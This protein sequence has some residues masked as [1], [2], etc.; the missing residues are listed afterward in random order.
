MINI[1]LIIPCFN[2]E[3][4]I[5]ILVKKY[6]KF[7]KDK[8]NELILIDNGSTDNTSEVLQKLKKNKNIK[9]AKV[10]KNIGFGY[11]L[12]KGLFK[13]RGNSILCSH[14]DMEIEPKD[15]LRS[16]KILKNK[17][18][19]INNKYFIKGNRVDKIKNNWSLIDVF[20]S[21]SLTIISTI[22]FRKFLFDIHGQPMLFPRSMIKE[23][24]YFPDDFSIDLALYFHA[25]KKNY[26]IIRYPLN[27][28]KKKRNY[29]VGNSNT[30][31]KQIK[32]CI[33]Q[34]YGCFNIL[35]N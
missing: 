19:K 28:N 12:K 17:K 2:E 10:K 15:I 24:K 4:N 14:A 26:K 20:F 18:N 8:K 13:A 22:L 16:I 1:S 5:P 35:F 32:A 30:I 11:G 23:I 33:E 31:G 3:K 6:R 27:F 21:F 34:L 25:T 29:G 7:L 9:I